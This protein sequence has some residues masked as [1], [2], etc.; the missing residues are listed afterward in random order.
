MGLKHVPLIVLTAAEDPRHEA[1][2]CN[3]EAFLAKPFDS[4]ALLDVVRKFAA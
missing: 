4:N 2:R 3:A 1:D